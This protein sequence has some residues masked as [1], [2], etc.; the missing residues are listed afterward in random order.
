MEIAPI[1]MYGAYIHRYTCRLPI[2]KN[3]AIHY[4]HAKDTE[5][6][7]HNVN[8]NGVLDTTNFTDMANRSWMF[9]TLGYGH[10]EELW[11]KI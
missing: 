10:S 6:I 11:K 1:P 7:T 3:N 2:G 4:F 9:R 8:L 5:I